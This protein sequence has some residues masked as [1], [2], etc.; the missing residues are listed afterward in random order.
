M[1]S[2]TNRNASAEVPPTQ[3]ELVMRAYGPDVHH[4]VRPL[5]DA[6]ASLRAFRPADTDDLLKLLASLGGGNSDIN[7][8]G[9]LGTLVS[10]LA[11][12]HVAQSLPAVEAHSFSEWTTEYTLLLQETAPDLMNQV[13]H[14]VE[15]GVRATRTGGAS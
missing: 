14:T 9:E 6:I 15:A 4:A 8:V 10:A 13:L 3:A 11:G 7:A 2:P 1:S 5:L 12:S